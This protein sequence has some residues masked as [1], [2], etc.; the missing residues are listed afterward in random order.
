M[1]RV[2]LPKV[3]TENFGELDYKEQIVN[4]LR[5]PANPQGGTDYEEMAQ[6]LPIIKK[7]KDAGVCVILEDAEHKLIA[8]RLKGCKFAVNA[9]ELFDMVEAVVNAP[10]QTLEKVAEK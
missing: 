9:D 4:V 6:V 1:K 2:Y 10:E 7:V 3:Q 5:S 8:Q